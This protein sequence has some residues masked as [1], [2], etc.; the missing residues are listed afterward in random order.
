MTKLKNSDINKKAYNLL[1]KLNYQRHLYSIRI[2]FISMM[3]LMIIGAYAVVLN[4]LPI[5]IYQDT[6]MRLFG[7]NWRNFGALIYN[8]TLQIATLILIFSICTNLSKWYEGN[9][10]IAINPI[11]YLQSN[12]IQL[13]FIK[14]L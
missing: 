8:S 9:M 13:I 1:H 4:N 12:W 7:S 6:M 5:P 11:M 10:K 2:S 14:K 3:P